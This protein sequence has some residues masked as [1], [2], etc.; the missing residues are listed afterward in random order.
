M[1]SVES[2][3]SEYRTSG[4]GFSGLLDYSRCGCPGGLYRSGAAARPFRGRTDGQTRVEGGSTGAPPGGLAQ[5][6]RSDSR[7]VRHH[8]GLNERTRARATVRDPSDIIPIQSS[9]LSRRLSS[10]TPRHPIEQLAHPFVRQL[11]RYIQYHCPHLACDHLSTPPLPHGYVSLLVPVYLCKARKLL[12]LFF[13]YSPA[14]L[15]SNHPVIWLSSRSRVYPIQT[16]HV[17]TRSLFHA[18]LFHP[19]KRRHPPT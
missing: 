19:A 16:P 1:L 7:R 18:A 14:S 9:P 10:T 11:I 12:L 8:L 15:S 2:P 13:F 5:G 4:V 3:S 6:S 17:R